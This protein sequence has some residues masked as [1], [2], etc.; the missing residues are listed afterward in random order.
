MIWKHLQ[1]EVSM[2]V[3]TWSYRIVLL[4]AFL[5][6]AFLSSAQVYTTQADGD[7]S[8]PAIWLRDG[9]S[10]LIPPTSSNSASITVSH[11]VTVG[12]ASVTIDQATFASGSSVTVNSG[13]SLTVNNGTGTD[14][15]A[16][17]T[18]TLNGGLFTN[19]GTANNLIVFDNASLV[20]NGSINLTSGTLRLS[21]TTALTGTPNTG[22][23][24]YGVNVPAGSTVTTGFGF[25]SN[26]PV[27]I[28]GALTA[29]ALVTAVGSV[30]ISGSGSSFT[31]NANYSS[32]GTFT[33]TNPGTFTTAGNGTITG[34]LAGTGTFT[35]SGLVTFAGVTTISG[36][37]VKTFN[38]VTI[39]GS[40][41]AASAVTLVVNGDLVNNGTI[42]FSAGTVTLTGTSKTLSGTPAQTSFYD[43]TIAQNAS[44]TSSINF[45]TG[46]DLTLG[47]SLTTNSPFTANGDLIVS[48]T[49]PAGSLTANA[50]F[51]VG[52]LMS[53]SGSVNATAGFNAQAALTVTGTGSSL[54]STGSAFSAGGTL[55]V[56][57]GGTLQ[58][59]A[60]FDAQGALTVTGAGSAMTVNT[61]PFTV[62]GALTV[63]TSGNFTA[64]ANGTLSGNLAGTSTYTSNA[65]TTFDGATTISGA[66][67]KTLNNVIVTG[68]VVGTGSLTVNGDL[69]NNGGTIN[70]T[71]GTWTLGG[72]T[73]LLNGTSPTLTSFYALTIPQNMSR[74]S[75][76]PFTAK[77][78]LTVGGSLVTN[79]IFNANAA[80]TIGSAVPVGS[81]TA[82]ASFNA[83]GTI[84]VGGS[85]IANNGFAAS[86]ALTVSATT[87]SLTANNSP[88]SIGGTLTVSGTLTANTSADLTLTSTTGNNFVVAT[89]GTFTSLATVIFNG[90]TTMT[91]AGSRTFTNIQVNSGR[92]LAGGVNFTVAGNINNNGGTINLTGGT[93]TIDGT[94]QL[95]GSPAPVLT[96]LYAVTINNTR[97]LL[98]AT[99]A[100]IDGNLVIDGA[101]GANN[102]TTVTFLG[103]TMSGSGA[104]IKQFNNI[105]VGTGTFTPNVDY[106][107][108]GN[109][110]VTGTMQPGNATTSLTGT[111][112]I[113]G[114]AAFN[115]LVITGTLL[116]AP[117]T[118]TILHN[119]TNNGT[120]S[121]TA[122]TVQFSTTST[123]QQ[124]I[125][126]TQ[127]I[128]FN[129][130]VVSNVGTAV[131]LTNEVDAGRVI[132]LRES[133]G[134]SENNSVFDAD[135]AG[136]N[137][138]FV[139]L[140]T[141][142]DPA[143]DATVG[144]ISTGSGITSG[145]ASPSSV[146]VQRYMSTEG[147]SNSPDFNNGRIYRYLSVPVNNPSVSQLQ[148]D[149]Y[150]T[151]SF[152]GADNG[153]TP[154]C[155]GCSTNPSLYW[156]NSSTPGYVAFAGGNLL[157]GVGYA[158]FIR[159]DLTPPGGGSPNMPIVIDF[160]GPI[161][162][163]A[164]L[165]NTI[166]SNSAVWNLVGNPYPS[167][168]TWNNAGT[169]TTNIAAGI[170]IQNNGAPG[171]VIV[172]LTVGDKIAT[173]Q[174]FWVRA[175]TNG[176]AQLTFNESDKTSIA[177]T[178]FYRMREE[179]KDELALKVV[180]QDGIY[181]ETIIRVN[182]NSAGSV[183][184]YDIPKKNG[185][186]D[187]NNDYID[188]TS[189][190]SDGKSMLLNVLPQVACGQQI[191]LNFEDQL[192]NGA[193][194]FTSAQ[195]SISINP[196]GSF[197]ALKW[198]LHDTH[199][200]SV[201]NLTT[202]P[203][204][205]F[206]I[207]GTPG[208]ASKTRFYLTTQ[209]T[210]IDVSKQVES[211]ALVCDESAIDIT[212]LNTQNLMTYGL[213]VNGVYYP[214]LMEG[215]GGNRSIELDSEM[216]T[217]GNNTIKVKVNSGCMEEFLTTTVNVVKE[218]LPQVTAT[219]GAVSCST[220]SVL[221]SASGAPAGSVY[222][223]YASETGGTVLATGEQFNTPVLNDTVVYYVSAKTSSGCKASR[224]PVV[225]AIHDGSSDIILSKSANVI[226]AG[227]QVILSASV[228]EAGG[229]FKWYSAAESG[230]ELFT[231]NEYT[232][233]A[234]SASTSYFVSFVNQTGCESARKEVR[235]EVAVF[236][237]EIV[238][239]K[240]QENVCA[241]SSHLLTASGAGSGAVYEWFDAID[242]STPVMQGSVF[243]TPALTETR[244]FYVRAKSES[245][246]V[247]PMISV[248]ANVN[249]NDPSAGITQ[250][251]DQACQN[252]NFTITAGGAPEG[253]TYRWYANGNDI[254]A[255]KEGASA[256]WEE[257]NYASVYY[258]SAVSQDGCEGSR[259]EM[260]LNIVNFIEARIDSLSNGELVSN[261]AE[262]N[263][264][265]FNDVL[266]PGENKQKI[267]ADRSGVYSLRVT[268]NGT[269]ETW[270]SRL[271]VTAVIT[272]TEEEAFIKGVAVYPNPV[273]DYLQ[274]RV[275]R[276]FDQNVTL[277]DNQG[278]KVGA[279]TL[280]PEDS[281]EFK[282]GS[283]DIRNL[284]NGLYY[285]RATKMD[286]PV[287]IKIIKR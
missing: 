203:V 36:N 193:T 104:G 197:A 243:E 244:M 114:N 155:T 120:C 162:A 5:S 192:E 153:S 180:R 214:N 38:N 245:G 35:S 70:P 95:G 194:D 109:I 135:G 208:S 216:L 282:R 161:N 260:T 221:L 255:A 108:T 128:T 31:A 75:S 59:N 67:V 25:T 99:D 14:L 181:D 122:G 32:A 200:G 42:N 238:I 88:F 156:Y 110:Q 131:D 84:T 125:S 74:T 225:A 168:I 170:A 198:E 199:T 4:T 207:D 166:S 273:Q 276:D 80:L 130:L 55:T 159:N 195:F 142:D 186:G 129:I 171:G 169:G 250:S 93:M 163:G 21:G 98:V 136:N 167:P 143:A 8:N 2:K 215:N 279:V 60:G 83:V 285:V 39:T 23:N 15:T 134:F 121:L 24:F 210:A 269:C 252:Q 275:L 41:S 257:V 43:L 233:P 261:H 48:G 191:Q 57:A 7:W 232:T 188:L 85:L 118:T 264:W 58:A 265:Y 9:V 100:T 103:L 77:S 256:T 82:N 179:I 78:T 151:G 182:K 222:S 201:T 11:A 249:T 94:T 18:L 223:W 211:D 105:A 62:A 259:K 133:I 29:N 53:V 34:N 22:T 251:V 27:T 258:M 56:S 229:S 189:V 266:L 187:L 17:G 137:R 61:T 90:T 226:C 204:Y 241:G 209:A 89:T 237:P 157:R 132:Y 69:T 91:Q 113:T 228:S 146:T 196:S 284:P 205:N 240:L 247:T 44:I 71:G 101:I 102:G 115:N 268:V 64:N 97:S 242:A 72:T 30:T 50:S 183:D 152:P 123:V 117:G 190:S 212:V 20:N 270:A 26:G 63:N 220:G 49:A 185:T 262:G 174:A 274:V 230:N 127:D 141:G 1:E 165:N 66:G 33:V 219:A 253:S 46:D 51:S 217:A 278:R 150:V 73:K 81:L 248:Q 111:T 281:G 213:E 96:R 287:F 263:Q 286:K 236:A 40:A 47:G 175:N 184:T 172:P 164:V 19:S 280:K 79:D 218:E 160:T 267:T 234:L 126:G 176:T 144:V 149:F 119:L 16:S 224:V 45:T 283:F 177:N 235:A 86:G 239:Q 6:V 154:G 138:T 272:G 68:S 254:V 206:T 76:I 277:M 158:A 231:G 106:S 124:V 145:G 178:H 173:G 37:G 65:L 148:D 12:I 3:C 10:T 147:G 202:N 52:A 112:S 140:S 28:A 227:E 54:T 13:F 107:I 139:L 92:S 271:N 116:S 87:G 246:C